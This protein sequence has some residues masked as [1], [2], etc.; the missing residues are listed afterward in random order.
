MEKLLV[1]DTVK[2]LYTIEVKKEGV[3]L[4]TLYKHL[5]CNVFDIA[6]R[7][8]DGIKDEGLFK[9]NYNIS[10]LDKDNDPALV[11]NLIIAHHDEEGNLTGLSD[12]DIK[13]LKNNY[14]SKYNWFE[15]LNY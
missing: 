5:K 8:I 11:G 6:H 4:D 12:E 14:N 2:G 10:A 1:L 13:H 3:H 7:S 15:N 9:D